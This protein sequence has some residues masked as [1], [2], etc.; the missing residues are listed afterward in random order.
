MM[1]ESV[2]TNQIAFESILKYPTSQI[3]L[4]VES[5]V[6][7]CCCKGVFPPKCIVLHGEREKVG[8]LYV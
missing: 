6:A 8:R 3:T 5:E 2:N 7:L 1:R 4:K